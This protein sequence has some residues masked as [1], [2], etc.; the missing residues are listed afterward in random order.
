M[1]SIPKV[2]KPF[3]N[4]SLKL[5]S[6]FEKEIWKYLRSKEPFQKPLTT[7]NE[8]TASAL[9]SGVNLKYMINQM[10]LV[11]CFQTKINLIIFE[12]NLNVFSR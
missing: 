6:G 1:N 11:R 5:G 12:T 8:K 7:P 9:R 3:D 2:K 10:P 4:K